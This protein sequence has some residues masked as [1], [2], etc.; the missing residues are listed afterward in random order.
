MVVNKLTF[1]FFKLNFTQ[2]AGSSFSNVKIFCLYLSSVTVKS[3]VFR[4][5]IMK[6]IGRSLDNEIKHCPVAALL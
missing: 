2:F 1:A 4:C 6:I 3:R 5:I